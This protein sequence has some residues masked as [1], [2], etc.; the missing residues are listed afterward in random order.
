MTA[1]EEFLHRELAIKDKKIDEL[2]K[3]LKRAQSVIEI[4]IN[5]TPTSFYRNRLTDLNIQILQ[6]LNPKT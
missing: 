2:K 6:A 3:V 4:V 5:A 1:H